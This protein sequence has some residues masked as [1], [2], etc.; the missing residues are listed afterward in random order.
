MLAYV[1][2]S[3][4]LEAY[5]LD[6]RVLKMHSRDTRLPMPAYTQLYLS[7]LEYTLSLSLVIKVD[8]PDGRALEFLAAPLETVRGLKS[9]I[10][11]K[12]G[13]DEDEQILV[14]L[15]PHGQSDRTFYP[16]SGFV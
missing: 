4:L 14:F 6:P 3:D 10:F 7:K 8:L 5:A 13:I 15:E 16:R 9:M 12:L 11:Q 1:G 2:E